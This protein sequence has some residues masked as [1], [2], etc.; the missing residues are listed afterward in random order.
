MLNICDERNRTDKTMFAY[1][2]HSRPISKNCITWLERK[3]VSKFSLPSWKNPSGA[4]GI[5]SRYYHNRH[6][7]YSFLPG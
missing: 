3:F 1:P 5:L 4:H 7:Q 6:H 2:E